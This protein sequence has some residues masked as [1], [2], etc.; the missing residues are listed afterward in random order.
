MKKFM[1]GILSIVFI[2]A[3]YFIIEYPLFSLH[4]MKDLPFLLA[5][6]AV[7]VSAIDTFILKNNIAAILSAAGYV[8]GLAAGYFFHTAP[9]AHGSSNYPAIWFFVWLVP[10]LTGIVLGIVLKI[11]QKIRKK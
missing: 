11:V 2:I 1:I 3:A 8:L 7:V 10:A 5:I 4:G 6:A 9:D